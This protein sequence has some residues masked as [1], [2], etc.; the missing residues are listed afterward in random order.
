L[1]HGAHA[2]RTRRRRRGTS[3]RTAPGCRGETHRRRLA[4]H[5]R[6]TRP[7]DPRRAHCRPPSDHSVSK[8]GLG[9][10]PVRSNGEPTTS[11]ESVCTSDR[12]SAPSP[13]RE[14]CSSRV[15]SKT[16]SSARNSS[17]TTAAPRRSRACRATRTSGPRT[18]HSTESA[19]TPTARR[20]PGAIDASLSPIPRTPPSRRSET[21]GARDIGTGVRGHP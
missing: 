15:P 13:D 9:C 2:A 16:S 7:R 8:Y 21:L 10:T 12:A 4:R 11:P 17:S 1:R 20:R 19:P 3:R 14:K 6:R 5:L 18:D